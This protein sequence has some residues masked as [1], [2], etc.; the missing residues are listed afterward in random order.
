MGVVGVG[1]GYTF[2]AIPNLI[3]RSVASAGTGGA[4]GLYQVSRS[5]GFSV[6]SALAASILAGNLIDR[7]TQV[8]EHGYVTALWVGT[9]ICA[10]SAGA[11]WWLP[12]STPRR[13]AACVAA[14]PAQA[15]E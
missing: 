8:G 2:A 13:R 1:F 7:G 4:M 12:R 6:G 14:A 15:G 11:S 3:I 10:I 9:A 5:I